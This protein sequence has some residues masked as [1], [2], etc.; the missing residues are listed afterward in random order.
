M[1]YQISRSDSRYNIFPVYLFDWY[2]VSKVVRYFHFN[3]SSSPNF[4]LSIRDYL[5]QVPDDLL[6]N[7][8][9]NFATYDKNDYNDCAKKL[10]AGWWYNDCTY[11]LPTG[12][13]YPGG[14]YSPK[15][16]FHGGM[17]WKDWRGYGYS[18]KAI[19]MFLSTS[20]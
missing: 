16:G 10:R 14:D 18:L 15:G 2:A 11:A 17:F 7:N 8:G 4:Q 3:V 12:V 6:Y 20:V 19:S 9:M 1:E 5:G 13:Y